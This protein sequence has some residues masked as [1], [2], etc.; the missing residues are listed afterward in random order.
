MANTD[1]D[2]NTRWSLVVSRDT[3]TTLRQFLANQ[4]RGHKGDL[5]R[6]VEEAVRA[7]VFELASQ[8]AKK[9]NA[10]R[11]QE[12]IENAIEEALTWAR[13]K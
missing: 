10:E 1:V 11:S 13:A 5:S 6:F 12:E 7:H 9:A 4:G 8:E 3:D 2:S